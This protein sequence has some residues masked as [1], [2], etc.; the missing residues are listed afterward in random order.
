MLIHRLSNETS[1]VRQETT[2]LIKCKP[3]GLNA[4]LHYCLE[5][6]FLIKFFANFF[7]CRKKILWKIVSGKFFA[8]FSA[9]KLF[10]FSLLYSWNLGR[11][12][13]C[14]NPII[15]EV[16]NPIEKLITFIAIHKV[17]NSRAPVVPNHLMPINISI[18]SFIKHRTLLA[19]SNLYCFS[20]YLSLHER[21]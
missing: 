18:C 2:L 16:L 9:R 3:V 14:F 5:F 8:S 20:T 7:P 13:L 6:A 19:I 21:F 11:A 17:F 15:A 10:F 4:F 1:C 12:E